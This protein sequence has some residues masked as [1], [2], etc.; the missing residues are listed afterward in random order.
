MFKRIKFHEIIPTN[1]ELFHK[2]SEHKNFQNSS[3]FSELHTVTSRLF[4]ATNS[5]I[6]NKLN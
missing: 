5:Q 1:P 3:L 6:I 4:R 2:H